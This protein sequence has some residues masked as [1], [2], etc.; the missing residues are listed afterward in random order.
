MNLSEIITKQSQEIDKLNI[1]NQ[2]L[3]DACEEISLDRIKQREFLVNFVIE[4][5][6]KEF[7]NY[8]E[9]EINM[10]KESEIDSFRHLLKNRIRL[11]TILNNNNEPNKAI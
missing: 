1:K 2:E 9:Q 3:I 11:S 5:A 6:V 10:D 4:E 7:Q 8:L